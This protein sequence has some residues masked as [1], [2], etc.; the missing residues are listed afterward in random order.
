MVLAIHHFEVTVKSSSLIIPRFQLNASI[1]AF[2]KTGEDS[3]YLGEWV[4]ETTAGKSYFSGNL[5]KGFQSLLRKWQK[6]FI[7]DWQKCPYRKTPNQKRTITRF[8]P[9]D[10]SGKPMYMVSGGEICLGSHFFTTDFSIYFSERSGKNPTVR[11]GGYHLRYRKEDD[12]E[13]I[14]WG[15]SVD[16][17]LFRKHPFWVFQIKSGL[18]FGVNKWEDIA[19]REHELYDAVLLEWALNQSLTYM[20]LD[21]QSV[22]LGIGLSESVNYIYSK[23]LRFQFGILFHLGLQL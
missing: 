22:T 2:Q 6:V 23:K 11:S 4:Y 10:Y 3:T 12:F 20:P 17:W 9:W 21:Q 14:E 18:F 13:S 16:R 19:K 8:R 5:R 1:K 7:S 15:L